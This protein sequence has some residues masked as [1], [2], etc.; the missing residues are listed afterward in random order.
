MNDLLDDIY[1]YLDRAQ[2]YD[3][4]IAALCCFHDD[5]RPSMFIYPDNYRCQACNAFGKTSKLLEMLQKKQGVF[6]AK[7][8]TNFRS[9]WHNWDEKYGDLTD[10]LK[11]AHKNLM[12]HNKTAYLTK[13]GINI[14]TVRKLGLGWLDDWITFPVQ[15][16]TGKTIGGIARAGETNKSEAKYCNYPGMNSQ[17]LYIPDW[18]IGVQFLHRYN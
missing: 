15:N 10:T 8:P 13:R 12:D 14:Q 5:S 6:I 4:Y 18:K 3:H 7:K 11:Y 16:C 9:P 2:R 1:Q 17:M